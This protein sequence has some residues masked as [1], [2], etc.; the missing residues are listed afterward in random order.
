MISGTCGGLL[1]RP[2]EICVKAFFLSHEHALAPGGGGQQ[3]CSREYVD[4]LRHAGFDLTNV[5]FATDRRWTTRL[6]RRLRP[7]PYVDLIPGDFLDRVAKAAAAQSPAY[8]FCN[9][10]NLIA[11]GPPLRTLLAR[12]TKLVL[13]SHGLASVDELHA[14][15]IARRYA[16]EA[17][18]PGRAD[19][20]LGAMMRVESEGLPAFD[21]VFTLAP[22]EVE[23]TRWLGARSV[24]WVPRVL[25]GQQP[26]PW[27]PQ[28]SRV[29]CVG[30]FDHPPNYEGLEMLCK[31]LQRAGPGRLRLRVVTRSHAALARLCAGYPFIDALGPMERTGELAAEAGTWNAFLHPLFCMAM[32][33]STKLATAINWG[34]PVL[35]TPAG[36][37][38]Y[39]W[40]EGGVS[41]AMTADEMARNALDALDP[42]RAN[43]L[44]MDVL[45]AAR[46]AP[47]IDE[48]AAQIRVALSA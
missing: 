23:I 45:R 24:S 41:L 15:R 43:A 29:G 11:L 42:D 19:S 17:F 1:R 22:F 13:L 44:R 20:R 6:R 38:G 12:E 31:A 4:A 10:Y 34:L 18:N 2:A 48:V 28:G 27:T 36:A 33:C 47:G 7:A 21:H 40:R 35:T 9:L 5:L 3:I 16:A 25:N 46:S 39:Q 26:L 30:T 32:G 8:V 14:A 37:R